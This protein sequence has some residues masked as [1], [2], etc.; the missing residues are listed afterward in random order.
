MQSSSTSPAHSL[1]DEHKAVHHLIQLLKQEQA[2]LID[3]D[4]DGLTVL[5]EEKAKAVAHMAELADLRYQALAAAGF[6]PKEA[7]MQEWLKSPSATVT[8]DKSWNELLT[9]ARSAKELNRTNGLLINKHM[10]R[11]QTALNVLHGNA[12]GGAFYGPDGQ[13]TA[14][15]TTRNLVIG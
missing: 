15:S 14:K 9:L 11:N 1:N 10:M 13:S 6:A 4:I 3:A 5:T 12:P 7:G 8:A 2:Q